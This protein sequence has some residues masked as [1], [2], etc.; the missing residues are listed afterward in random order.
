LTG[1]SRDGI[2]RCI[3]AVSTAAGK[4]DPIARNV[5]TAE[6]LHSEAGDGFACWP[7][8]GIVGA[9]DKVAGWIEQT[10]T[11]AAVFQTAGVDQIRGNVGDRAV[12]CA[13]HE[14]EPIGRERTKENDAIVFPENQVPSCEVD[15]GGARIMQFNPLVVG[16]RQCASPCNLVD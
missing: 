2:T 14:V 16:A 7:A 12:V 13:F 5:R 4:R 11:V 9:V 15:R 6:A 10:Q 1:C 3:D 8:A